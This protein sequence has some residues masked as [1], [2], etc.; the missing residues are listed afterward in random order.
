MFLKEKVFKKTN[1]TSRGFRPEIA[2]VCPF[3]SLDWGLLKTENIGPYIFYK[4]LRGRIIFWA[5][6]W[7]HWGILLG[8]PHQSVSLQQ[9]YFLLYIYWC[10]LNLLLWKGLNSRVFPPIPVTES[11]THLI[12]K[13]VVWFFGFFSCH[14]YI[15]Q[16]FVIAFPMHHPLEFFSCLSVYSFPNICGL[17]SRSLCLGVC[18]A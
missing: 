11:P 9:N 17:L 3:K 4:N 1:K 6:S 7:K 16:F 8:K 15:L 2:L 14:F 12:V 13:G 10:F 18:Q 5:Q